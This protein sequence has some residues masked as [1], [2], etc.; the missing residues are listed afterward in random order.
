MNKSGGLQRFTAVLSSATISAAV[1][2][3]RM[4]QL[5]CAPNPTRVG[6]KENYRIDTSTRRSRLRNHPI[7][8]S[9]FWSACLNRFEQELPAQQF[10]TWIKG[11]Q[12]VNEETGPTHFRLV[13]PNRFVM[14]W[15]RE[16]YL[17]QIEALGQDFFSSPVNINLAV[18]DAAPDLPAVT[19]GI[20]PERSPTPTATKP[21]TTG[22]PEYEKTR[23]NAEF[24]F[25]TL[26]TGRAND[27]ASRRSA[28]GP[29]SRGF[30]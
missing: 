23:L 3:Y 21:F 22:D 17:A 26:V 15:V 11:L 6:G 20:E 19:P 30:L 28:G 13:A 2:N 24:T 5:E 4:K 18:A 14:Q 12:L 9:E 27:L 1:D 8:M 16:R 29:E 25:D 10:N 7:A